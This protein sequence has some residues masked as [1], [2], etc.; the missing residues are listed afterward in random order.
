M[1]K[2]P[3]ILIVYSTFGDGH[4]QVANALKQRFVSL[5]YRQIQLVDLFAE[6]HPYLNAISRFVYLKSTVYCPK[7]YGMSYHWTN[8]SKPNASLYNWLHGIGRR[9][10]LELVSRWK[11]DAVIHTF[12]FLAVTQLNQDAVVNVPTFTV[13][14]DYVPHSRW[15]HTG[16]DRYF[17]AT[18]EAKS[19]MVMAG[20]GENRISVS[21]IPIR[22]AF[23][24][25]L[26]V[27]AIVRKYGLESG[28]N[29][30]LLVAGAYG[31]LSHLNQLLH[32][33]LK[34]SDDKVLL[35]CGK[36]R[37]LTERLT[38]EYGDNNRVSVFGY[39]DGIEELMAISSCLIT[40]A[41][42]IT[43]TEASAMGLP[44]IVYRPLPGQEEENAAALSKRGA[45]LIAHTTKEL[46]QHLNQLKEE[47][48]KASMRHAIHQVYRKN[49]G[50]LIVSEVLQYVEQFQN[51]RQ[52]VSVTE[53]RHTVHGYL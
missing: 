35:V 53:E 42:G 40:K 5:G 14:T 31:V 24:R 2:D 36:N 45:L 23:D 4:V 15:M 20:V 10:M 25:P 22:E 32:T 27:E 6:S 37:K 16:T 44:V 7:M 46:E 50:A 29:Y 13:L 34:Q 30:V 48:Y 39:V 8:Q 28:Q 11:P 43:L 9:K 26:S 12:P 21:G 49:A 41:G 1:L 47:S 38:M 19:K 51:I 33:V 17:V 52:R 3:S 18:D